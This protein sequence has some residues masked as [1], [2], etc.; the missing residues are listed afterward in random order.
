LLNRERSSR[1]LF[2]E[3]R[4]QGTLGLA[5]WKT[6]D[7]PQGQSHL[8]GKVRVLAGRP[9]LATSLR[10][11]CINAAFRDPKSDLAAP[12]VGLVAVSPVGD[13]VLRIPLG[14]DA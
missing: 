10:R 9:T 14:M 1:A 12:D 4:A 7:K 6:L 2:P 5:K 8:G 13:A 11:P 3:Q